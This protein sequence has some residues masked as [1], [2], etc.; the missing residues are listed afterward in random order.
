MTQTYH[1]AT[2]HDD[3][4]LRF[5]AAQASALQAAQESLWRYFERTLTTPAADKP[6]ERD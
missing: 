2:R 1:A 5:W 6:H 4:V 3:E